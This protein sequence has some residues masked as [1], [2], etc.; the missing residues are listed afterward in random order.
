MI[1]RFVCLLVLVLT[2]SMPAFGGH[3]KVGGA[4]CD[5][6]C[7]NGRCSGCGAGCSD[8]NRMAPTKGGAQALPGVTDAVSP[9]LLLFALAFF[10]VIKLRS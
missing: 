7:V 5:G 1:K 4:Y 3:V 8:G 6:D 9:E 10:I 2:L